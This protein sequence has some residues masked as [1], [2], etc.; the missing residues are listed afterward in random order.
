MTRLTPSNRKQNQ[1][2]MALI[3]ILSI[4]LVSMLSMLS[5]AYLTVLLTRSEGFQKEQEFL[6][7]AAETGFEYAL[8]SINTANC[9]GETSVIDTADGET[10]KISEVPS[11]IVDPAGSSPS[12]KTR[13]FL[14]VRQ[15]SLDDLKRMSDLSSAYDPSFDPNR[16]PNAVE[17]YDAV[18]RSLFSK[19]HW[20]VLEVTASRG[21]RYSSLRAILKPTISTNVYIDNSLLA[22]NMS[23]GNPKDSTT[24]GSFSKASAKYKGESYQVYE[25]TILSNGK[26]KIAEN[27]NIIGNLQLSFP[28]SEDPSSGFSIGTGSQVNGQV[29]TNADTGELPLTATP[30]DTPVGGDNVRA[31]A[32]IDLSSGSTKRLGANKAIP[33]DASNTK[34]TTSVPAPVPNA[35]SSALQLP[36]FSSDVA[37]NL[38]AGTYTT[39]GIST[40]GVT[41]P[42][43]VN[44]PAEIY[45]EGSSGA[46]SA[47]N[48][49][50]QF[51][52]NSGPPANLK[53]L[54][55]GTKDVNITIPSG[56]QMNAIIYAPNASVTISGEGAY[57][58]AV[59]SDSLTAQSKSFNMMS[60]SSLQA[61]FGSRPNFG[62]DEPP[63]GKYK[64]IAWQQ[65]RA[66]LVSLP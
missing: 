5:F 54:Y 35:P 38:D 42:M 33:I 15:I 16:G 50:A 30:G 52:Q 12:A 37:T 64:V 26:V 63:I 7:S 23:L 40:D 6:F 21:Q 51:M 39:T 29:F 20:R 60:P 61:A 3:S 34:I 49:N 19:S 18:Q 9:S 11:S 10:E 57:N 62:G 27:T 31:D 43:V 28:G 8:Y 56:K 36:A 53:L 14:K 1:K 2:G 46:E 47:I 66:K 45:V 55:N 44:G 41:Q 25:S 65:V 58:G 17:T 48:V 4:G 32:D 24:F 59:I 22:R 13:V